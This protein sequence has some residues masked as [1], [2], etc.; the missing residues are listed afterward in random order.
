MRFL[1]FA[2][3]FSFL[4]SAKTLTADEG[5]WLPSLIYKL[6]ISDMQE[7]GLKLTA[8]DIYSINNSSLKDAIAALDRGSCTAELISGNGLLLTNHHCG[9]DEIQAHSSVEHDYL[10]DGFWAQ[11]YDEEL[12]NPGK[13]ASFL[14]KVEDVSEKVLANVT[15]DMDMKERG[16]K[17]YEAVREIEDAE[18]QSSHY[19]SVVFNAN[20]YH[21]FV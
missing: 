21:L 19:K 5:M 13:S 12:P 8:E 9:Y 18:R 14:V 3:L 1:S 20:Q 10:Q 7:L 15:D 11:S 17:I 6:N 2:L 4:F 16:N